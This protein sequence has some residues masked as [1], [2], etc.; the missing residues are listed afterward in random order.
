[1]PGDEK[2]RRSSSGKLKGFIIASLLECVSQ[3]EMMGEEA[4]KKDGGQKKN[5]G[6]ACQAKQYAL[7]PAVKK[8]IQRTFN[9]GG[10]HHQLTVLERLFRW[11]HQEY[12]WWEVTVD[13]DTLV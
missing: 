10:W 5:H 11:Q 12:S 1:M 3:E 2:I 9:R 8:H 7:Y 13:I 6:L 4:G